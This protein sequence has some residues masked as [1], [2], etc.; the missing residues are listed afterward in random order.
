MLGPSAPVAPPRFSASMLPIDA[1]PAERDFVRLLERALAPSFTLVR[2]LGAGAMGSVYL[3]RDPVLKRLVAVKVMA[4]ALA[5]DP[6]ARARFEREAQTVASISHPNV[7][8]VYS[9][10]TLE[11][12]V[13]FLVMQYVEGKTLAER[14]AEG[15]PLDAPTAKRV[16][17]EVASALAAAHRKGVIHRD[18]KPSNILWDDETGRALVSDF[19]IAAVKKHGDGSDPT[20]LTQSGM[21]LGT[22]AYMSPEQVRGEEVSEKTDVYSLGVL[23]YELLIGEGPYQ[24]ANSG[25]VLAA[26][27][28]DAPRKLSKMRADVDP[29]VERLLEDCLVKDAERRPT[30]SE[31]QDRLTHGASILLEWPPPGLEHM[32]GRLRRAL[33][34]TALGG[35]LIG[36]PLVLLSTFDRS[37]YVRD[38]LP[39]VEFV[40]SVSALGFFVFLLGCMR[41]LAFFRGA[42]RAVDTGYHWGTIAEAASDWSGDTGSLITGGREYATLNPAQRS[43]F[44]RNRVI[45][46]MSLL[47][48]SLT[49]VIGFAIGVVAAARSPRGPQ[50]V[51]WTSL[52]LSLALIGVWAALA[53]YEERRLRSARSR[54]LALSS[55]HE[56]PA[57]LAASWT[58]TF[59]QVRMGQRMGAGPAG[60]RRPVWRSAVAIVIVALISAMAAD[61]LILVAALNDSLLATAL[62]RFNSVREKIRRVERLDVYIVPPDR[63]IT[64]ERAGQALYAVARTARAS[65]QGWVAEPRIKLPP[66][67]VPEGGGFG[68]AEKIHDAFAAARRGFTD[69]QRRWLRAVADN[70]ALAEFRLVANARHLDLGSALFAIPPGSRIGVMEVPIPTFQGIRNAALSNVAAAAIDLGSGQTQEAERRLREVISVGFLMMRDGRTLIENLVGAAIVNN[71]RQ[72]LEAF[73]L[74]TGRAGEARSVSS[75]SDPALDLAV[76]PDRRS[77]VPTDEMVR[78]LR[79]I[80]LDPDEIPGMRWE[81]LGAHSFMPCTDARQIL[82][83]PDSAQAA[84]MDSART[85]L[86]R[87]ASDSVVFSIFEQPMDR[88]YMLRDGQPMTRAPFTVTG[89]VATAITGRNVFASCAALMGLK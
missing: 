60:R 27:L 58:E 31:A 22:P 74:A 7:V 20:K 59:D 38:A 37:S 8:A 1:D 80:V 29:E 23:G 82:F 14:I 34:P 83:G 12:G 2:R 65:S 30:S 75:A 70:P 15:G 62:P 25:E 43:T 24:L 63:T 16:L 10:G 89:W 39:P 5:S 88:R 55:V 49:P 54:R 42:G 9:V 66:F 64:A 19:G 69:D 28:R 71:A 61:F 40:L 11:N 35:A 4:P 52:V 85:S 50:V 77:A 68:G 3:A 41:I 72:S 67:T 76:E 79:R 26:H 32:N 36:V 78:V 46:T 13:P 6:Q 47:A 86:V 81:M 45:G 18:I 87:T 73:F 33:R 84:V 21:A 57:E 53:W 44:R 51:L 56:R 48:S 17:G